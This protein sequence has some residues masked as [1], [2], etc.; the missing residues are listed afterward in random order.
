MKL[1]YLE[2][3]A[4]IGVGWLQ[5]KAFISTRQAINSLKKLFP[6]HRLTEEHMV[7]LEFE[8]NDIEQ[9][10]MP[11]HP[12]D[13]FQQII[14]ATNTYLRNNKG[15]ADFNIIK[16]ISER[17]SEGQEHQIAAGVTTPLYLGLMG[18]FVGVILG[19]VHVILMSDKMLQ[20]N[21]AEN[22]I[23]G[24]LSGVSVAMIVSLLGL[25]MTTYNNVVVLRQAVVT[26]DRN[27]N[28][29]YNFLQS[30]LLPNLDNNLYSA[31]NLLK[32]NIGDFN[33]KFTD[34][35]KLFDQQFG[36]NIGLLRSAVADISGQIV[37]IHENTRSQI[38]FLHELK[39][40]DY[41]AIAKSNI[42]MLDKMKDTAPVLTEFIS[43]HQSFNTHIQQ[44]DS[45]VTKLGSLMDRVHTFEDSVNQLGRDIQQS[46][47]LGG[48]VI[49][50]VR[51]HLTAIDT[52]E[53]LINEYASKSYSDV[54]AYLQQAAERVNELRRKIEIDLQHAFDF[55]SEGNLMQ[56]LNYLGSI[57]NGIGEL[58]EA[59]NRRPSPQVT[60]VERPV[61]K[62]PEK[63]RNMFARLFRRK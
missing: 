50:L 19:L 34:N 27:K 53:S 31:L 21:V 32:S 42:R 56:N 1:I 41:Q 6:E 46:E 36:Q 44:S 40:V 18:T 24:L 2:A 59:L 28:A 14:V 49:N 30:E 10:Q 12:S 33:A 5:F 29:Y 15:S 3:I 16:S 8:G 39:K 51:K 9:L 57:N 58:K 38:D 26:R 62:A 61:T 63:R 52:K 7:L 47:M 48:D 4:L 60:Y 35:L 37:A 45:L 13:E 54:Q 55:Q 11:N 17:V 43:A 20:G 22:A 25:A 23:I